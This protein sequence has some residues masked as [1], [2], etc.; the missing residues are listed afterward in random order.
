MLDSAVALIVLT[1]G[2]SARMG[3]PKALLRFGNWTALELVVRNAAAGGVGR[4]AAVIGHR[5]EEMRAAHSFT[6]VGVEFSWVLN[7]AT[8]SEQIESLQVGLRA[9]EEGS[10]DAFFFMPVDYPLVTGEDFAALLKAYRE[11]Q[12]PERVFIPT[13]EGRRGHPVL[14]QARMRQVIL[15]LAPGKTARDAL[16]AGGIVPVAVKNRGI[17]EDM[18]TPEDYR[19]LRDLFRRDSLPGG[20]APGRGRAGPAGPAGAAPA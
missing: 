12:G 20:A 8:E 15:D 11:H 9:L 5:A 18:N 3:Q 14:C 2:R 1:A 4:V 19:R 13:C 7:R 16:E 6:N 10:L 17:L